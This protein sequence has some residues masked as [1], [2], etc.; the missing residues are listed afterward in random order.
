VEAF[1]SIQNCSKKIQDNETVYSFT[2][3]CLLKN[4]EQ[5][6]LKYMFFIV[7]NFNTLIKHFIIVYKINLSSLVMSKEKLDILECFFQFLEFLERIKEEKD[8]LNDSKKYTLLFFFD[9]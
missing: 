6:L 3:C 5:D 2:L 9:L 7:L 8:L 1:K 4:I